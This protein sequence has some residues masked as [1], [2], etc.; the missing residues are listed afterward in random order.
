MKRSI[1]SLIALL[2]TQS[3]PLQAAPEKG[4]TVEKNKKI[5]WTFTPDESLPNVLIL[6]DSIS[7]GYTLQVRKL[8]AGKANV[9]RPIN[10]KNNRPINCSGTLFGLERCAK[11]LNAHKWDVI[12]FNWGLHDLKHVKKAGSHDKSNDPK[13]PR[14]ASPEVYETKLKE[15]VAALQKTKAKLVFATTTP[16]VPGTLN[17]LR[18]PEDPILYNGIATKIMEKN[19]IRINDLHAYCLPHLA[20]WQLP[21]NVH[22]KAVGSQ[23]LAKQV[24]AV[25]T[26]ELAKTEK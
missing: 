1:I 19:N 16:V 18:T 10:P 23:A 17:P 4:S 2:F 8:L 20:K 5:S 25:I 6:G 24:S 26:E 22:F 9:Y 15:I 12:H 7:I 13:S 11:M 21:K 14:Q 3:L